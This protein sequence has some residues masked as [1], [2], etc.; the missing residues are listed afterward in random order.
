MTAAWMQTEAHV[1]VEDGR[2]L[3]FVLWR[4][5]APM[6]VVS[7]APVGGGLGPRSWIINAQVRPWYDRTD[8]A[9]HLDEL[10]TSAG[11]AVDLGGEPDLASERDRPIIGTGM[12]TAANVSAGF[13]ASED[14]VGVRASVGVRLP[15]WAAAPPPAAVAEAHVGT[16]NIVACVPVPHT[17]AALVNLATTATEAKVQAMIEAGLDGTGT[18][19]DAICVVA[20]LAT[21][22]AAVEP[23]GGPRST[24]GAPLAR[25]VHAA[26]AAGIQHSLAV[27]AAAT[28]AGALGAGPD[29]ASR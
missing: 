15:V 22:A 4:F 24:C 16:I 26:V 28:D 9:A 23:F 19:T 21:G 5:P 12:L 14:G 27:I 11:L 1:R 6:M 10:A 20:P 29:R 3:P 7:S 17:A 18:V 25:A 13:T 8:I 2:E